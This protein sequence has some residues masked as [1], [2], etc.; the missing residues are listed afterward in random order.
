[1]RRILDDVT[2][3]VGGTPLVRLG[4]IAE[5]VSAEV[6]V[7]LEYFNPL[8]SIKDRV[9]VS[10]IEDAEQ[11]GLIDAETTIIEPTSGNTGIGLAFV[12]ACRGYR[13]I[14]TM[15][16]TMSMERQQL[17]SILGAKLVLTPGQ[18]GMQGAIRKAEQ[19]RDEIPKSFLPQQF[20]NPTNPGAHRD[21]TAV[22][23]W[24]DTDGRVDI[25]VCG[26]GTGG[27][28]TGTAEVLKSKKPGIWI[29]AVEPEGSPVLSGGPP[30]PHG[31]FGI[32][33]GFVPEILKVDYIDEVVTISDSRAAETTIGLART[34]GIL[35][36]IS[37][38]AAVR[39]ALDV[40]GRTENS[41]KLVV[42]IVPDTGERYL[43][44]W[45]FADVTGRLG[46]RSPRSH[47]QDAG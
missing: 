23:I 22:E 17:L 37:S 9:A 15:P 46:H 44:T 2:K 42:A 33:A 8:S 25:L 29:V 39:A 36:G 16:E 10:M 30:G 20:S 35:A 34:E 13:L 21:T 6:C 47:S 27:T 19:L 41:G 5:G 1:M 4:R 3:A 14:L 28:L 24:E 38:G 26:V 32:G 40:A 31:I 12:C 11:R 45:V 7:K 43:S 18:E